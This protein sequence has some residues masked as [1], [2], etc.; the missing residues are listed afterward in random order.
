MRLKLK[1]PS[2]DLYLDVERMLKTYGVSIYHASQQRL[3]F[4]VGE[5]PKPLAARLSELGC[6][7]SVDTQHD[8]E[9]D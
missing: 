9:G 8:L 4:S 3:L 1:V 2:E 7:T 5:I 6:T